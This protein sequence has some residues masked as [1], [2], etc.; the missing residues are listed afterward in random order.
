V[1]TP[2]LIA[3]VDSSARGNPGP[4]VSPWSLVCPL[5]RAAGNH[6]CFVEGGAGRWRPRPKRNSQPQAAC[7]E[8]SWIYRRSQ[9][10]PS[11]TFTFAKGLVELY[12]LPGRACSCWC[13]KWM[14]RRCPG[15]LARP[16]AGRSHARGRQCLAASPRAGASPV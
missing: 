7:S 13:R 9:V 5:E 2:S 8:P 3:Q 4:G 10:R 12:G 1:G 6:P 15:E 11:A 16:T 14:A